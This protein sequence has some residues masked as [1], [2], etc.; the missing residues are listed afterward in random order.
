M[1]WFLPEAGNL[2]ET[3]EFNQSASRSSSLFYCTC[4]D[5]GLVPVREMKSLINSRCI[6]KK[7]FNP[8]VLCSRPK[9]KTDI[10]LHGRPF[11]LRFD[12]SKQPPCQLAVLSEFS[13]VYRR[14]RLAGQQPCLG[15]LVLSQVQAMWLAAYPAC[16]FPSQIWVR[17]QFRMKLICSSCWWRRRREK[18]VFPSRPKQTS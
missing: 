5:W 14:R 3:V 4:R 13:S 1:A 2:E 12:R 7:N 17:D 16:H 9:K 15:V 18:P 8:D 6:V 11:T 10:F